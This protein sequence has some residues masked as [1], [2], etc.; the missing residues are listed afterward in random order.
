MKGNRCHS[1]K[2]PIEKKGA[3]PPGQHGAKTTGRRLSDFGVQLKEKQK[4][5]RIYGANEKQLK[6]LFVEARKDRAATGKALLKLLERRLDNVVYRL[7]LASSRSIGRYL[8]SH[9]HILVNG[10]KVNIAS[11]KVKKE[12]VVSL[13]IKALR[14]PEVKIALDQ[15]DWQLPSW[16]LRK[17]PVGKIV[18]LPDDTDLP[19]EIDEQ[20]IVEYYSR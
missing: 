20:L 11:F 13:G 2:C 12:D 9:N 16:L 6:N 19:K 10:K 3:V 14:V 7:G 1:P 17:G 15:K 4:L 5:K 18:G 8:V